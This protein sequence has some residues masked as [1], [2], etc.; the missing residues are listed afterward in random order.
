MTTSPSISRLCSGTTISFCRRFPII[1]IAAIAVVVTIAILIAA[2]AFGQSTEAK[3]AKSQGKPP[4]VFIQR[5]HEHSPVSYSNPTVFDD[6]TL[7]RYGV[8]RRKNRLYSQTSGDGGRTWSK[9]KFQC[10]VPP[11]TGTVMPLLSREGE[12]HLAL[13]VSRGKG[14]KIAVNRFIDI[15]H[16]RTTDKRTRW[17]KPNNIFKGY[18]GALLDFKQC[19]RIKSA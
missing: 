8:D 6:G 16:L 7:I 13:M 12:I 3:K 9:D 14:R 17:E 4:E 15:W 11:G 2:T 19:G 10:E 18:C 5:H 1:N